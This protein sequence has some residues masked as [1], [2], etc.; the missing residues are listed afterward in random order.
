MRHIVVLGSGFGGWT[1]AQTLAKLLSGRRHVQITIV[2]DQP[3]FLFTPLLPNVSNGELALEHITLN[4]RDHFSPNISIV[5]EHVHGMDL[6]Q[7]MLLGK[8]QNIPFD[9][10]VLAPG[11]EINWA[12]HKEW[13]EHAITCKSAQDA[14]FIRDTVLESI[15]AAAQIPKS[16]ERDRLMTLVFAGAGPTGMELACELHSTLTHR[17]DAQLLDELKIIVI[18]PADH[19]LQN[20]SSQIQNIAHAHC[21]RVGIEL[22][23]SD[24]VT[25]RSADN[26][27]LESGEVIPCTHFFWCAGICAPA[28]L[29]NT[30]LKLDAKGR[31][32]VD[33]HLLALEHL[34]IFAI[35][36]AASP[37]TSSPQTAQAANQQ[38]PHAA[39]NLVALLSGRAMQPWEFAHQGELL[40]L[41]RPN[42]AV[43]LKGVTLEGRAAYALYRLTYAS[44]MPGSLNTL[45]IFS[46]WLESD[47]GSSKYSRL[48]DT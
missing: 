18:D 46:E 1:A 6:E 37:P 44:L 38:G 47:L 14:V 19:I 33:E 36:D 32:L 34:G 28:W 24:R 16:E 26:V 9:Y 23:L 42:A 10:I 27:T 43:S 8:H 39:K 21:K 30:K 31:I 2:S 12:T 22:R 13:R 4:L 20:L 40:T 48:L 11:S 25:S 41:G 3:E 45:R 29:K 7:R 5:Q 15:I 17:L 35:G